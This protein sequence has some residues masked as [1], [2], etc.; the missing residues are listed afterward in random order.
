MIWRARSGH[1]NVS[2]TAGVVSQVRKKTKNGN[3]QGEGAL[4]SEHAPDLAGG[5]VGHPA[6]VTVLAGEE[7]ERDL[8]AEEA[9]VQLL[10]QRVVDVLPEEPY[11]L[12]ARWVSGARRGPAA[13]GPH[14]IRR[15]VEDRE[16]DEGRVEDPEVGIDGVDAVRLRRGHRR[17]QPRLELEH[18]GV[19]ALGR[20]LD[21]LRERGGS[22][23]P[24]PLA[25]GDDGG[26]DAVGLLVAAHVPEDPEDG[27]GGAVHVLAVAVVEVG[28]RVGLEEGRAG[29]LESR[30]QDL[31]GVGAVPL[32][33]AEEAED[34]AE[35]D[36]ALGGVD[37]DEEALILLEGVDGNVRRGRAGLVARRGSGHNG[38][39]PGMRGVSW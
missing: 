33:P 8:T 24:R 1:L 17:V 22:G 18:D 25:L 27:G 11:D 14:R 9:R 6:R 19:P 4:T 20:P 16:V 36:G 32:G 34:V 13:R 39:R 31:A 35:V 29:A 10:L 15:E 21:G 38:I 3:K 26:A 5:G 2:S 12:R 30:E 37:V 7:Q 28:R 23:A